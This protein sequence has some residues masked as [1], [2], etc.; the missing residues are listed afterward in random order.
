M[1]KYYI[2]ELEEFH[3]GFRY[4]FQYKDDEDNWNEDS[5]EYDLLYDHDFHSV[6]E[7]V[8]DSRVR[9]KYLDRK[10][11]EELGWTYRSLTKDG[12]LEIYE[13][14]SSYTFYRKICP[15]GESA[16][17]IFKALPKP[18]EGNLFGICEYTD[19]KREIC[20]VRVKNFNELQKLMGQLKI[21]V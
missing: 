6:F 4:E 17:A 15:N 11:I 14:I 20:T 18:G 7:E 16:I 2:P 12:D 10:D 1:N 19:D 5:I 9:I 3:L 8:K 21:K 13:G